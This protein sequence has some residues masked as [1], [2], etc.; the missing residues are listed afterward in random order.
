[1]YIYN[2]NK[3]CYYYYTNKAHLALNTVKTSKI[4]GSQKNKKESWSRH[5]IPP[6]QRTGGGRPEAAWRIAV[7]VGDDPG[8]P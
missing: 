2:N 8:H 7:G 1:M 3:Y 4:A 5:I 6:W